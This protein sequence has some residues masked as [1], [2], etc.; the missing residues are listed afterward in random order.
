MNLRLKMPISL[1]YNF[2]PMVRPYQ[3]E[4]LSD[5]RK[6]KVLVIHRR[7][8][9]TSLVLNKL[10]LEAI[11]NP[12]KVFYYICPTQKQA[13]EI[14]WKAPDM[15]AKYL[16][17]EVVDKKN[18]V[19]LTIYLKN[20]SQIHIKGADNPDSLR[21]VNPFGVAID[22]YAQ[23]KAKLYD[24]VIKPILIANNGWVWLIGTPMGRNDFWIKYEMAKNDP[25]NWQVVHLKATESG[26][27]KPEVLAEAQRTMT[28]RAFSQEF[29]CEFLEGE[30]TIFRRIKENVR[31]ELESPVSGRSY[32]MGV[33]L[34]RHVDFTVMIVVDR[35]THQIVH[36]DRFNQ[37]DYQ[38]QK[39]RIEATARRYNNAMIRIDST[40]VGD[41]IAEDLQRMGLS[42]T[43]YNFTNAS[44]KNLIE[45]LALLIE[46]QKITYPNIP[47]L[48]GELEAF[49]YELLA[50]GQVR[51][52]APD[53]LHDDCVIAMALAYFEI[54]AKQYVENNYSFIYQEA[55]DPYAAI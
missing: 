35:T 16:P 7:A 23:I 34:A 41:P 20:K 28:Q 11:R 31:G 50:S 6:N 54:G 2:D 33:D 39:A 32:V 9:K 15:L 45:N 27:L 53:G 21:G 14:A 52:T 37:I 5:K 51:Y 30:G 55:F 42:I 46:Q 47:E 10:I 48:I 13:K 19:E 18:E 1:P 43:P 38:L 26:I 49:T 3:H 8:G 17:E 12:G 24:E 25:N 29:L 44:K 40:G 36:F 22:E 4:I